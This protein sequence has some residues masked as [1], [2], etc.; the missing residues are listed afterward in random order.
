MVPNA[1]RRATL[2]RE[3]II[4]AALAVADAK[5]VEGFTMRLLG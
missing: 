3:R 1:P 5:G 2:S 4:K